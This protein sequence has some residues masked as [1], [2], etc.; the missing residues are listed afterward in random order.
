MDP[1]KDIIKFLLDLI[2][3]SKPYCFLC[4]RKLDRASIYIC[5]T[6]IDNIMPLSGPFCKNAVNLS[7]K[8]RKNNFA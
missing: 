8:T 7:K 1:N 3:P 2:F 4:N 6:C 5:Q